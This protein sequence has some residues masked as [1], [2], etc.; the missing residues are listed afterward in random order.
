MNRLRALLE[1]ALGTSE[2]AMLFDPREDP[3]ASRVKVYVVRSFETAG[4]R[5]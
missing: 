3:F 2:T 1:A 5:I 4:L